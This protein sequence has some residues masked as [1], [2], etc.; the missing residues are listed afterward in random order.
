MLH[1][2]GGL[3]TNFKGP[4]TQPMTE[5]P[6]DPL[7]AGR[8][9]RR[10]DLLPKRAT[11]ASLPLSLP[12]RPLAAITALFTPSVRNLIRENALPD[13][14]I[15]HAASDATPH[16]A[17]IKPS[18]SFPPLHCLPR[19]GSSPRFPGRGFVTRAKGLISAE[20]SHFRE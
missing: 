15:L 3:F 20:T 4:F 18:P 5:F 14:G 16:R 17:A 7:Q 12:L 2:G 8:A 10:H 11:N 6:G 1:V 13:Y 19:Y 9:R